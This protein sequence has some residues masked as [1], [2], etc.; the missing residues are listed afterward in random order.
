MFFSKYQINSRTCSPPLHCFFVRFASFRGACA[1]GLN[2]GG[3][4]ALR[5]NTTENLRFFPISLL[6]FRTFFFSLLDDN[7]KQQCSL[8]LLRIK[9]YHENKNSSEEEE[10]EA[11]VSEAK[12]A[13]V[14]ATRDLGTKKEKRERDFFY[15]NRNTSSSSLFRIPLFLSFHFNRTHQHHPLSRPCQKS[16]VP[17]SLYRNSWSFL[18]YNRSESAL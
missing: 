1:R 14:T 10:E 16:L 2:V 18:Y 15:P 3:W 13:A 4:W 12:V 11:V 9:L 7:P 17:L 8:F 5:D 6:F